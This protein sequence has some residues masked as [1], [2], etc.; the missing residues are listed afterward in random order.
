MLIGSHNSMG[1][2]LP[3]S[4]LKNFWFRSYKTQA[5]NIET[6]YTTYGVRVFDISIG[7]DHNKHMV[8]KY[9]NTIYKTFSIY[10]I[11][12]YLNDKG[13][14]YV[15][16]ILDDTDYVTHD[17]RRIME[18]K[19]QQ[20]CNMYE[21]IYTNIKFFGGLKRSDWSRVYTFNG[22]K[23]KPMLIFPETTDKPFFKPESKLYLLIRKL[24]KKWYAKLRNAYL[25][26]FA[27]RDGHDIC[28]MFDHVEI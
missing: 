26:E 25:K 15:R 20:Q 27:K 1:Y 12:K 6:Q 19:F 8:F 7:L 11:L 9:H 5:C 24:S 3:S 22:E 23:Y 14:C 18:T 21:E 17:D 10:E 28:I 16:V 13:D 4:I 2:L